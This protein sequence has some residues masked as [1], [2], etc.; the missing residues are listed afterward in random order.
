MNQFWLSTMAKKCAKT[1]SEKHFVI[2][3]GCMSLGFELTL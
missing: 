3:A 2:V 1:I